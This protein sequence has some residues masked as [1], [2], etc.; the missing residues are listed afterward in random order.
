MMANMQPDWKIGVSTWGQGDDEKLLWIKDHF[1]NVKKIKLNG[2]DQSAKNSR[3]NLTEYYQPALSWTKKFRKGNLNEIVRCNELN[4]QH[5]VLEHG[6]PDMITVQGAY[7]GAIIGNYLS[8]KY[9]IPYTVHVRLGGY[10]FEQLLN[11]VSSMKN[12]LL[13]SI[14]SADQIFTTSLFQSEGLKKWISKSSV[15]Y[16][17]VDTTF[18]KPSENEEKYIIAIG[19]LEKEKGFDLLIDAIKGTPDV[20]LKIG[21]TGS[22]EGKLK[23]QVINNQLEDRVEFLG[24]L[25][26]EKVKRSITNCQFLVLP[27]RYETFGNVL[28]EAMSCGKPVVATKCGGAEEIITVKT[29]YLCEI[30][31][32][33]LSRSILTMMT[34]S[35]SFDSAGIIEEVESRFSPGVWMEKIKS[36]FKEIGHK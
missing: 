31:S 1:K 8:E 27:S 5:Y 9:D 22:E 12:E 23:Q 14:N 6:P 34:N 16:N 21:G 30:N 2:Q 19:R 13:A 28:L 18:F 35:Q 10:M 32:K 15:L 20:H 7:P 29:G 24:E 26:R 25:D 36:T 11:E 4:F 3:R 17:P 33:D